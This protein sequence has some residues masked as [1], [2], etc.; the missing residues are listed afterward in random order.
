MK[1]KTCHRPKQMPMSMY[2]FFLRKLAFENLF[3]TIGDD[4]D[5]LDGEHCVFGELVEGWDILD[6]INN[7][8]CD[9]THRPYQVHFHVIKA[10]FNGCKFILTFK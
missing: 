4:L 9:G 3:I 6:K 1:K 7:T 10:F 5:Y 2:F 8:I